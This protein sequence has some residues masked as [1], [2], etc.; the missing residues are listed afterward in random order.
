[1]QFSFSNC[2]KDNKSALSNENMVKHKNKQINIL[3]LDNDTKCLGHQNL[4]KKI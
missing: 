3:K 4:K 1:M 2:K